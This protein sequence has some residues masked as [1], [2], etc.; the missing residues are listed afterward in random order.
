MRTRTAL[1]TFEVDD[2][3]EDEDEAK[4]SGWALPLGVGVGR[5]SPRVAKRLLALLAAPSARARGRAMNDMVCG[6]NCAQDED[7]VYI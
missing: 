6:V 5:V 1:P 2:E 3:A 7:V 4:R